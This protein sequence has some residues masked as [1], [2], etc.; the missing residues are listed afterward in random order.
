VTPAET[1]PLAAA[2]PSAPIGRVAIIGTGMIGTSFAAALRAR[3]LATK[4]VGY[5]PGDDAH[6]IGR[7]HV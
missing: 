5:S 7:A 1:H 6:E 2:P 4:V 3:A